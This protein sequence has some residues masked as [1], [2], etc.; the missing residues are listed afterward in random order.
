M[1]N[2]G[3]LFLFLPFSYYLRKQCHKIENAVLRFAGVFRA[4]V[5]GKGHST[6]LSTFMISR[7]GPQTQ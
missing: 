6:F 3:Q 2:K 7:D 4:T 5:A 1:L